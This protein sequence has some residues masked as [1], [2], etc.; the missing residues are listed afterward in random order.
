M[1]PRLRQRLIIALAIALGAFCWLAVGSMV[2][3]PD[4]SP[5]LS[6]FTARSGPAVAIIIV[7][8]AG[9]PALV[10]GVMASASG[11]PL[12][13]VF[14]VALS[15]GILAGWGGPIDGWMRRSALPGAYTWLIV[16]C[17]VWQAGVIVMLAVIQRLRASLRSRL[18]ALAVV[19]HLG[20]DTNLR[21][22]RLHALGAGVVCAI[23]SGLLCFLLIRT[24]DTGQVIGSLI[25]AFTVGGMAA[26]FIFP[27]SN[28]VGILLSPG[29]VAVSA[30]GYVLMNLFTREG[31]LS[32]WWSGGFPG[33]ALVLPIYYASFAVAA[34]AMG[35]GLAQALAHGTQEATRASA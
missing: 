15:L 29:L 17:V 6:L 3:A 9:V 20:M 19:D 14:A 35:V 25:V 24:S 11:H 16:E 33:P 30:Y 8:V 5:G 7:A 31:V 32:A 23:V 12:S 21:L 4:N 22:P 18:P 10:L 26:Q 13:G 34:A 2:A 27:Q 28:P 1:F